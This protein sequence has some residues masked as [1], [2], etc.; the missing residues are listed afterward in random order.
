MVSPCM[1]SLLMRSMRVE[2]PS[3]SAASTTSLLVSW[4]WWPSAAIQ[5][6]P[7][8]NSSSVGRAS[9]MKSCRWRISASITAFKRGLP[10]RAIAASTVGV[11]S[12][13]REISFGSIVTCCIVMVLFSS[14]QG[15]SGGGGSRPLLQRQQMRVLLRQQ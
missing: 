9:T 2:A 4:V 10:V 1:P 5:R 3:T 12:S 7:Y 8:S 13:T 6:R 11:T 15:P 14:V